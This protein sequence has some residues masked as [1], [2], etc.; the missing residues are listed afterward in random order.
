MK[1][2]LDADDILLVGD[3]SVRGEFEI[4]R[5]ELLRLEGEQVVQRTAQL[6]H[7]SSFHLSSR[8]FLSRRYRIDVVQDLKKYKLSK[9][10]FLV[11]I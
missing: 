11:I 10:S 5:F 6:T 1:P 3:V 9:F 4:F 7:H 8:H 2:T